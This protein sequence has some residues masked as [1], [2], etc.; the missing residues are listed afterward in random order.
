MTSDNYGTITAVVFD[1]SP[2][3]DVTNLIASA[4]AID[5][6]EP[7]AVGACGGGAD[8]GGECRVGGGIEPQ[9]CAVDAVPLRLSTTRRQSVTAGTPPIVSVAPAALLPPSW[10][11]A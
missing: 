5:G 2:A 7:A 1:C 9:G 4:G 8:N 10:F 11:R 6:C 3:A